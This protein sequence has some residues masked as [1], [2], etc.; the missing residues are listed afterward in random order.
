[1]TDF[2]DTTPALDWIDTQH[3]VMVERIKRWCSINSGSGNQQGVERVAGEVLPVLKA[4][5]GDVQRVPLPTYDTVD[6]A[7]EVTHHA[8]AEAIVARKRP[9]A[10]VQVLLCIHLDTVYG[11]EHPFQNV[12]T[13][14]D[15]NTLHGPGV[16][17]AMGG[18]AV[19]LTALEALEKAD[20][21]ERDRV[22]W[23]VLLNPD[24]EIG[25]P[26]SL[27][28]LH[29]QAKRAHVGMV[30]EPALPNGDIIAG[31]KGSGNFAIVIRGKSAHAGRAFFEGRNAVTAGAELALQLA[32]L[33]D[34][35]TG[36]TVNVAKI[37]GGGANN[38]V[39]DL[40]IVRCNA[41]V[42][43]NKARQKLETAVA[44]AVASLDGREGFSAE[45]HGSF[46]NPPKPVT[47]GLQQLLDQ[48]VDAGQAVGV[49]FSTQDSGGVCDGNKFAAAGL[50]TVDTLGPVGGAIHSPDEYL[51]VTSL[52]PRAKLS[53]AL[54]LSYASGRFT[55]PPRAEANA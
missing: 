12:E 20:A 38:V 42:A 39:P 43:D 29:D 24:E 15:G 3:N 30:Y 54:L 47:P 53:A 50:P 51:D 44:L 25:S 52:V 28:L 48:F 37:T 21:E 10:P 31:R 18:L 16:A 1:M 45:L 7:G 34:E 23:T 46:N 22:G 2:A 6:D 11:P 9:D 41:R 5:T 55:P 19:M 13:I 33:T 4:L 26:A 17:D 14:N 35:S 8:V 27:Q 36:T 32:A 40:A 49:A